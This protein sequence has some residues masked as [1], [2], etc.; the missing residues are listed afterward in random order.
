VVKVVAVIDREQ[1]GLQAIAAAGYECS[2]LFSLSELG[3]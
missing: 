1:D 2:A 3:L